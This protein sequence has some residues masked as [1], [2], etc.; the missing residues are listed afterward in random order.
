MAGLVAFIAFVL[1]AT[2]VLSIHVLSYKNAFVPEG[3][4][5]WQVPNL[6]WLL[7]RTSRVLYIHITPYLAAY[8]L[9]P[10]SL[11]YLAVCHSF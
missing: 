6:S 3:L 1:C 8:N 5:V 9:C 4:F 10:V 11:G 2:L 7:M